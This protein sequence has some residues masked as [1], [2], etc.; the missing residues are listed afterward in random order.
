MAKVNCTEEDHGQTHGGHFTGIDDPLTVQ[1]RTSC[2]DQ[3]R[4]SHFYAR[5]SRDQD[6]RI[7]IR[8]DDKYN[9]GF[10]CEVTVCPGE[11]ESLPSGDALR[12]EDF[13]HF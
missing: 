9:P 7:C 10:W 12:A 6:G 5:A 11:L 2:I 13:R 4:N 1:G 3:N 8:I